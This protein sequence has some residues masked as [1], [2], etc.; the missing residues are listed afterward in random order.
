M[1]QFDALPEDV[2]SK[3]KTDIRHVSGDELLPAQVAEV[4]YENERP[5][6]TAAQ[7]R[8]QLETG[9]EKETV[10]N[11]LQKLDEIGICDSEEANTGRIYWLA[12]E[13]SE[14]P[15][16]PDVVIEGERQLTVA[17]LLNPWYAKL[18][19]LGILGPSLA[20]LPLL[21]G[22]LEIGGSLSLPI[23][24]SL[25][26][27]LGLFLI[28]FSYTALVYAGIMG[29]FQRFASGSVDIEDLGSS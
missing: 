14:W 1:S 22:I 4:M 18:A 11:K 5:F 8:A 6:W 16:P 2:H 27:T 21:L 19:V 23:S 12:D 3:L 15:I 24:G 7:M 29:I 20:G 17:E 13:R 28:I 25:L 9:H 26:L 10:R